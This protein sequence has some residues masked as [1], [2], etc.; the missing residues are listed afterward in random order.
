MTYAFGWPLQ[1]GL[2]AA[3]T[4]HAGVSAIAGGRVHDE[5]PHRDA[6][7][8]DGDAPYVLIGEESA[9]PWSTASDEGAAHEIA[10]SAV[11]T[12]PG[13]ATVK[14]LAG[15]ICDAVLAPFALPRGRVVSARLLSARTARARRGSTRRIDMRFRIAIE[16]DAA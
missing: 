12:E 8:S 13:F 10:I 3:L 6:G 16:D 2:H 11:A 7:T 5:P 4:A 9:A 1:Q 14:R 15:A